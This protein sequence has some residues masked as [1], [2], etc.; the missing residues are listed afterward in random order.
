LAAAEE[1]TLAAAEEVTLAAA[2]EVT[3][4]AAEEVTLAAAEEVTLFKARIARGEKIEAYETLRR[5]RTGKTLQVELWTA[6]L[7]DVDGNL[8]ATVG[9]AIDITERKAVETTRRQLLERIVEVQENERRRLSRE[10]HDHL[11]QHLTAL[12]LG[13]KSLQQNN[14]LPEGERRANGG[15]AAQ[16]QELVSDL[17]RTTHRLAWELRPAEL[18]DMGLEAALRRYIEHWAT[19]NG[20]DADFQYLGLVSRRM[21]ECVETTFFRVTQEALTNVL[22]HAQASHVSVVLKHALTCYQRAHGWAL[23][24]CASA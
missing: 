8:T 1:V 23:P 18:D 13:L 16:L 11:G 3:L 9:V 5:H 4:A 19:N 21:A 6:P 14:N 22:R 20:V 15:K 12:S 24:A 7:L 2:E 10:L 17:M